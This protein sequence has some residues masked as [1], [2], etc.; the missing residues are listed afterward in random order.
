[1][2]TW[3]LLALLVVL[4]LSFSL[5]SATASSARHPG[6]TGADS[7]PVGY[8]A[9]RDDGDESGGDDDRW[10]NVDPLDPDLDDPE[11][12]EVGEGEEEGEGEPAGEGG[13]SSKPASSHWFLTWMYL[14]NFWNLFVAT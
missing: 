2:R 12:G 6:V 7:G 14:R 11:Q 8:I 9:L 4:A 10:G 3:R 13:F 1:M 5:L